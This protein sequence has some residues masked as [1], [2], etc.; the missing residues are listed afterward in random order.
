MKAQSNSSN[1]ITTNSVG[2]NSTDFNF[3]ELHKDNIKD[4]GKILEVR[5]RQERDMHYLQEI[6]LSLKEQLRAL[7]ESAFTSLQLKTDNYEILEQSQDENRQQFFQ[8][9]TYY[10]ERLSDLAKCYGEQ[11]SHFISI[12]DS[13]K[14]CIDT[15]ELLLSY[16][17]QMNL[18]T[19]T[20]ESFKETFEN[21]RKHL[22]NEQ[23]QNISKRQ[24]L[25]KAQ[26]EF[27][28]IFS[29]YNSTLHE[30]EIIRGENSK[31]AEVTY[32]FEK[33]KE[34]IALNIKILEDE[35]NQLLLERKNCQAE[36]LILEQ[37]KLSLNEEKAS[38]N[39][40]SMLY[41][42]QMRTLQ[43]DMKV[44]QKRHDE[45]LS[46]CTKLKEELRLKNIELEGVKARVEIS[47]DDVSVY[48]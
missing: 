34:K 16:S 44:L 28:K 40:Q 39:S 4:I 42:A 8:H 11:T 23:I 18:S 13:L 45:M 12:Q 41:E 46:E 36:H 10:N 47:K 14:R 25:I 26:N 9:F 1:L 37:E 31:P 7:N 32:N 35:K 5:E 33:E 6:I 43:D 24:T 29:D 38:L 48:F 22:I 19:E 27:Q 30:L 3:K 17:D 15:I 20:I 21:C 2:L